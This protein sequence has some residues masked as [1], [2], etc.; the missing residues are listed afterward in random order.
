MRWRGSRIELAKDKKII[1]YIKEVQKR[2][3][4][5]KRHRDPCSKAIKVKFVYVRLAQ[6]MQGHDRQVKTRVQ[7]KIKS[8]GILCIQE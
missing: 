7:L 3:Q 1:Y 2:N 6:V 4:A 5:D 8:P